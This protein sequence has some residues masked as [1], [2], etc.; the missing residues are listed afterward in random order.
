MEDYTV[1]WNGYYFFLI[2]DILSFDSFLPLRYTQT[3]ADLI[4]RYNQASSFWYA[5][6]RTR[7]RDMSIV[8][9]GHCPRPCPWR[10]DLG[11]LEPIARTSWKRSKR[12]KK[13]TKYKTGHFPLFWHQPRYCCCSEISDQC[14]SCALYWQNNMVYYVRHTFIRWRVSRQGIYCTRLYHRW[15]YI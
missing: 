2:Q 12:W 4:Q 13:R 8:S 9:T 15:S 7:E 11:G 5:R 14:I 6:K 3:E 1:K 10:Y